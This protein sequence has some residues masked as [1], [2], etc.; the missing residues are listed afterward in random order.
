[1]SKT[2]LT[3]PRLGKRAWFQYIKRQGNPRFME[4]QNKVL[5]RDGG[6]CQLCGFAAGSGMSVVNRDHNY[7]NNQ[8]SNLV[9]ACPLCVQSCFMEHA[10]KIGQGSGGVLIY[11]PELSQAELN[12]LVHVLFCSIANATLHATVAQSLY[13]SLK[14]RKKIVEQKFGEINTNPVQLGKTLV[15]TPTT[16]PEIENAVL[17]DIRLLASMSKFR[18]Q[19]VAWSTQATSQLGGR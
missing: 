4:I 19:I 16:T 6:V 5:V 17:R 1:L 7:K 3:T 8:M 10:D 9:S 2:S 13:N 15:D 14:L 11:M 12:G 18:D